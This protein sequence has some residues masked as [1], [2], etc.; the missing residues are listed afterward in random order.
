[1]LIG[2][3]GLP[4]RQDSE[5]IDL[6]LM[7]D[8]IYHSSLLRKKYVGLG[9]GGML[10]QIENIPLR[11]GLQNSISKLLKASYQY[12]ERLGE[13]LRTA[14]GET[15]A[16]RKAS[17]GQQESIR[18]LQDAVLQIADLS[19]VFRVLEEPE[20]HLFPSGQ[21]RMMEIL[22][23]L[24]NTSSEHH[25]GGNNQLFV[26]THSPYLLTILNNQL[27]AGELE[28]EG[29][30]SSNRAID[31]AGIPQPFRLNP[32]QVSAYMLGLDG[33]CT[34]INDTAEGDFSEN[35]TGMV[36]DNLLEN[37]WNVL[38]NQF[39]GLMEIEP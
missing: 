30:G 25:I 6:I 4:K 21:H 20:A 23:A 12:S 19:P 27:F 28:I 22:A 36:G 35:A 11:R 18:I 13:Y 34:P 2:S 9:M 1:M 24:V 8:F 5:E 29:N 37:Y 3:D 33:T 39:D 17:S 26:T 10:R 15:I 38:Q 7:R 14:N 16:L 31:E 32:H